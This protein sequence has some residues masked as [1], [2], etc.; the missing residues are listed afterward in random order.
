MGGELP[1][2]PDSG[3]HQQVRAVH[4]PAG[5][6]HLTAGAY[7]RAPA[8]LNELD[9]DRALPVEHHP[10]RGGLGEQRQ[11]GPAQRRLEVGVG[12]APSSPPALGD[13]GLA[14]PSGASQLGSSML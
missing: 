14:D 10:G 12:R 2:I 11:V 3:K 4:R 7:H 6:H 5:K 9:T 13:A 1:A 8:A